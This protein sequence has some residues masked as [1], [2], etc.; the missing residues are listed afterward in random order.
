MVV[1][2]CQVGCLTGGLGKESILPPSFLSDPRHGVVTSSNHPIELLLPALRDLRV[3]LPP[4]YWQDMGVL[5]RRK[6]Q[7]LWPE[8]HRK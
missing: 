2:S 5:M 8:L 1:G 3:A 4:G 7:A 6:A